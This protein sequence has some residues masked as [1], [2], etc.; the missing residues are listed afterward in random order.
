MGSTSAD[1]L[2]QKL[3]QIACGKATTRA[4]AV[5]HDCLEDLRRVAQNYLNNI[6]NYQRQF[7]WGDIFRELNDVMIA[8]NGLAGVL[9]TMS[10]ETL[11]TIE[12]VPSCD[13]AGAEW[14]MES[15]ERARRWESGNAAEFFPVQNYRLVDGGFVVEKDD[16][17]TISVM[18][19]R[20]EHIAALMVALMKIA[21]SENIN[22]KGIDPR[23]AKSWGTPRSPE[24]RMIYECGE[25]LLRHGYGLRDLKPISEAIFSWAHNGDIPPY[26]WAKRNFTE[27]RKQLLTWWE[28]PFRDDPV[29]F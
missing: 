12:S 28:N 23:Y 20:L 8:C 14:C 5:A 25:V 15:A 10:P 3:S 2:E 27:T 7:T 1:S 24:S 9:K 4:R 29:P 19:V 16:V 18:A 21:S 6:A 17:P 13:L 22:V 11:D 26:N